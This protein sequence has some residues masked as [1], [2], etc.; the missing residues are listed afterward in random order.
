MTWTLP[1]DVRAAGERLRGAVPNV[2]GS[3]LLSDDVSLAQLPIQPGTRAL[4]EALAQRFGYAIGDARGASV[5][6][7]LRRADGSLRKRDLHEEGRAL[8]VMNERDRAGGERVA[9]WLALN[10]RDLG[11]QYIIFDGLELSSS[12]IGAAWEPYTGTNPHRD[13]VHV[14]LSPAYA[15]DGSGMRARLGLPPRANANEPQPVR[16]SNVSTARSDDG[17]T[18]E[19]TR[20]F[21]GPRP[22]DA[23]SAERFELAYLALREAGLPTLEALHA[24]RA[25]IVLWVTETGWQESST[26]GESNFNPGNITGHSPYGFFRIP[27][28]SRRFRAYAE[29]VDGVRDA[30]VVLS[31]GRYRAAWDALVVGGDPVLWYDAILRAGYTGWSQG[32]V[33]Q[34]AS[35]SRRIPRRLTRS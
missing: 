10:A 32:L 29:A 6:K 2:Q 27:G 21:T 31:T 14:E 24:A 30:I 17:A 20:A 12:L 7:P 19:R 34:F 25:L 35:V 9:N 5:R 8:D 18:V 26:T 3:Q 15:A 28:N 23:W 33:D 16:G 1:A 13:H 4:K 11:V 22:F